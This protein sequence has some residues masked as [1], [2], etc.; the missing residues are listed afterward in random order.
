[1]IGHS[2]QRVVDNDSREEMVSHSVEFAVKAC[3]EKAEL[4][5]EVLTGVRI[6]PPSEIVLLVVLLELMDASSRLAA[7]TKTVCTSSSRLLMI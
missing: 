6:M 2:G 7:S 5:P 3:G 4:P 1:M